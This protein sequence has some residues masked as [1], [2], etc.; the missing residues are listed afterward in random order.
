MFMLAATMEAGAEYQLPNVGFEQ[1]DG[2]GCVFCA[3]GREA[4]AE[5]CGGEVRGWV[6]R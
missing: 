4:G 3:G 1:W 5:G 2:C 6:A